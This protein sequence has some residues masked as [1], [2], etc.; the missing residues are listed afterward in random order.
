MIRNNMPHLVVVLAAR[1][2]VLIL[3]HG[4]EGFDAALVQHL[5]KRRLRHM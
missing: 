4:E 5:L 3:A 1:Q 2:H